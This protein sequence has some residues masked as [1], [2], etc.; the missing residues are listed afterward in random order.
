MTKKKNERRAVE[1]TARPGSPGEAAQAFERVRAAAEALEPDDLLTINV[2]IPRA[3]STVLGAL[4]GIEALMPAVRGLPGLPV[5]EIDALRDYAFAAWFTHL[6][7]TPASASSTKE[8]LLAEATPLREDMLVAADA[9]AHKGLVDKET[10]AEIRR[11]SG[12]LDKANDLVALATLFTHAWS[13]VEQKTTLSWEE[14]EKAAELGPKLMIALSDRPAP[15]G[16]KEDARA[17]AF[18]LF[19]RTYDQLR[20]AVTFLRWSERDADMIAPSIYAGKKRAKAP[21][22]PVDDATPVPEGPTD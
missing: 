15:T 22:A 3:V 18:T 8:Q 5:T 19:A 16:D 17:R 2:D 6:A 11:G 1:S 7:A 12:N 20:R 10:V 4:P 14:V 21:K 9:L 13:R